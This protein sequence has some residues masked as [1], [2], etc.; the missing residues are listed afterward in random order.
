MERWNGGEGE[1]PGVFQPGEEGNG[2]RLLWWAFWMLVGTGIWAALFWA[3]LKAEGALTGDGAPEPE[4]TL[5]AV[6]A[7]PP[8]PIPTVNF[9]TLRKDG[10]RG[11]C[12]IYPR[13]TEPALVSVR[14][15]ALRKPLTPTGAG[16]Y[17]SGGASN[18]SR[19]SPPTQAGA[20]G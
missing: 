6:I 19:G 9:P 8:P 5:A 10:G 12:L 15:A 16:V 18:S 20:T 2:G 13:G 17:S 4:P 14:G 3:A 7:A 1:R 11:W